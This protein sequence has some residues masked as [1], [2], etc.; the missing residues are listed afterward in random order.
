LVHESIPCGDL[1]AEQTYCYKNEE[2]YIAFPKGNRCS[3][4]CCTRP[5]KPVGKLE[6]SVEYYTRHDFLQLINMGS[7]KLLEH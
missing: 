1:P 5:R 4:K 3:W 6:Y 2:E 7:F